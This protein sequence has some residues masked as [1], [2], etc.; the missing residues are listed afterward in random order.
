[1]WTQAGRYDPGRACAEAWVLMLAR[2]RGLDRLR[3]RPAATIEAAPEP[4]TAADPGG[5]LQQ[6]EEAARVSAALD[7]L[8]EEQREPI[9]LAFYHGMTHDP[10]ARRLGVPLG[11]VKTRIRLGMIRLRDRVGRP[12]GVWV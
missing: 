10:I 3:K 8:P 2:S 11:T 12:A 9:R 7:Y 4:A 5:G 6:Q 1:V